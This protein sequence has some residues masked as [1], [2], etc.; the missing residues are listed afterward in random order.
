MN[1]ITAL[2]SPI[3]MDHLTRELRASSISLY[4]VSDV[5]L[6]GPESRRFKSE[7]SDKVRLEVLV[8]DHMND[9]VIELVVDILKRDPGCDY[10]VYSQRIDTI[11]ANCSAMDT[12]KS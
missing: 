6:H 7:Y 8:E 9:W 4:S 2:V 5:R 11:A 10:L 1:L 12:E 3:H